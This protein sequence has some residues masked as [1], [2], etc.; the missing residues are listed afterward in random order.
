MAT[1]MATLA[2]KSHNDDGNYEMSEM[3]EMRVSPALGP[4]AGLAAAPAVLSARQEPA[5]DRSTGRTWSPP[6]HERRANVSKAQVLKQGA[7]T[8]KAECPKMRPW[9]R[10]RS[11]SLQLGQDASRQKDVIRMRLWPILKTTLRPRRNFWIPGTC[12]ADTH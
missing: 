9:A 7:R 10:A 8:C 12:W 3:N 2:T 1:L 5:C 11:R 4:A 6:E